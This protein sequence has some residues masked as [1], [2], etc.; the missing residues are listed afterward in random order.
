M[1]NTG[2]RKPDLGTSS[3]LG[4][5]RKVS[6]GPGRVLIIVE[7]N[8]RWPNG[9]LWKSTRLRTRSCAAGEFIKFSVTLAASQPGS[10]LRSESCCQCEHQ[11][12]SYQE[13]G[14]SDLVLLFKMKYMLTNIIHRDYSL[15]FNWFTGGETHMASPWLH[16]S[17][18]QM[19][20]N[21]THSN[22]SLRSCKGTKSPKMTR[23]WGY[24]YYNITL[25]RY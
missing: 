14:R 10:L 1:T 12:F 19:I 17:E 13:I 25:R 23:L 20:T 6:C 7:M 9:W 3:Y 8:S 18:A 21:N 22:E 16:L 15:Y 4:C 11:C 24:K 5:V 2:G